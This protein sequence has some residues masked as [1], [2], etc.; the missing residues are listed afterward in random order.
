M[1]RWSL[2]VLLA[3]GVSSAA[4]VRA[5]AQISADTYAAAERMLPSNADKLVFGDKIAPQWIAGSD[6]FWYRVRTERGSEFVVVDPARRSR[7]P[8]FD[9]ARLITEL[10][11]AL[12][13]P[14]A[15][16]SLPF[17]T[18][19]W[20][21]QGRTS[22]IVITIEKS[23]YRCDLGRY[24]CEPVPAPPPRDPT[25]LRSPDGKQAIFQKE[26]NLWV[27]DSNGAER[28]LTRDG[29]HRFEYA[30]APESNTLWVTAQRAGLPQPPL[31]VWSPDSRRILTH[32][33][34]QRGMPEFHLV[35][36]VPAEG[37]RPKL[38]SFVFPTPG[39]S[40]PQATWWVID[41][42]TGEAVA[43]RAPSF[44]VSYQ[45]PIRFQEAWWTDSVTAYYLD[46]ARGSS[47]FRL[48]RVDGRTGAVQPVAE[49]RGPTMVEATLA[50]GSR[51]NIRVLSGGR[52]VIWFSQRDGWAQ[53]YL[54]DG[55][56]GEIK[57]R[58]TNGAF[59]VRD[60]VHLDESARRIWFTA[61]GREPGR[62]PYFRHLYSVG[63]DGSGLTLLTPEDAE[64]EITVSPSGRWAVDRYSRV[65]LAPRTVLRSL[66]GKTVLPLE[67]ADISRLLATGWRFPERFTAKAADGT[68][69]IYGIVLTPPDFDSTRRYPVLEENYPGPQI[70]VVP[71]SFMAGGDLRAL[72]TLGFVGVMVDGR[73]T[74]F[75]SKA[76][77]DVSYGRFE[78][79]GSLEDHIEAFRQLG[80]TRPYLDLDRVGIYGHSG[81]GFASARA[82]FLY[83]D[84][85]KVAVSSAGNHDQRGYLS[86]WGELYQ[87]MP[88]G[89]NYASQANASIAKNLKGKL[90]LAFADLDD[91]VS[92]ALTIQ[93]VDALTQANKDYDLLIVPN[94][95]HAMSANPYFRRRRWD[96]FVQHLMGATPPAGYQI[97][98]RS[99]YP[100]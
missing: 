12:G 62:D 5:V 35:Q 91:N 7:R 17:E 24:R 34:D 56:T 2:P 69:D 33:L 3:I 79:A 47:S 89:D 48:V 10:S 4:P 93:V 39:D 11:R 23:G 90:L 25:E 82:M 29:T 37:L 38:W 19:T 30:S 52:E 76:F 21:E 60:I 22:A 18:L 78:T 87:G 28:Q 97:T 84:F 70:T 53:L 55:A 40:L 50:L 73:G 14:L 86:A 65:D 20:E 68:T 26:H 77:H 88:S 54:L 71:R 61:N 44:G 46:R 92:P 36:S 32:R 83:P 49:E 58:I 57:N 41:V 98:T 31:A 51:P 96:Y 66:D 63:L 100:F 95:S 42:P 45:A 94:G 74:P 81:G 1:S 13:R 72:V 8:A 43:V 15:G 64:H 85:Y 99:E 6:R 16:D 9:H 80:R 27:R 67:T 75:R 59:V